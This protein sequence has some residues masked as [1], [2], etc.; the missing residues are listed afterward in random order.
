[1]LLVPS[2]V[3]LLFNLHLQESSQRCASEIIAGLISGSK[4]WSFEMVC[5]MSHT[6]VLTNSL[7]LAVPSLM[8]KFDT[9]KCLTYIE[10]RTQLGEDSQ[11]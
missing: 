1:M 7:S 2:V 4:H 8:Q 9:R 11:C 6:I 10:K 3:Y 5:T